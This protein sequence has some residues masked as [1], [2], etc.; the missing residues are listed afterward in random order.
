MRSHAEV[1][2]VYLDSDL[3]SNGWDGSAEP[4]PGITTDRKSVV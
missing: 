2:P 1:L 4:Y 3:L